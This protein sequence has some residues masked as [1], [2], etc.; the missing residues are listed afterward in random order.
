M[1][2]HESFESH[3]ARRPYAVA[4]SFGARHWTYG[5]LNVLANRFAHTL[6]TAGVAAEVRVGLHL[7]P[8]VELIAAMLGSMKAGG[9]YVPLDPGLPAGRLAQIIERAEP[10][11]L[12]TRF[13]TAADLPGHSAQLIF[14]DNASTLATRS[15]DP[16]LP[17]AAGDLCYVMFTSGS[18]GAP[19][20]VMVTHGNLA[21]LFD[22]IGACLDIDADDV[23]T[24]FHPFSFGFSVW[25]IWCALRHGGRLVI[26][27]PEL[28]TDP[29]RLFNLMRSENVT[30][31]SQTP[32]AF[33][34]NFLS[35]T[36][37]ADEGDGVGATAIRCVVLSGEAVDTGA[38][39]RWFA[40]HGDDG[41]RIVNTYAITEAAGQLTVAEYKSAD[42]DKRATTIVGRPLAHAELAIVDEDWL[43]VAA[44][45]AGELFVGGP[46]VAGTSRRAGIE[47]VTGRA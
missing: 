41:P 12:V 23:W 37:I 15:E 36:F 3:A 26:V 43:P 10:A 38:L 13:V 27:P 32:S 33:R 24:T 28:R 46:S 42:C 39:Q 16:R 5:E 2:L 45:Q 20:G 47:P 8:G 6:I 19:K 14:A 4:L 30:V 40:R 25:E 21:P 29:V 44:G 22:D 35:D 9:A 17:V 7:P 18:T 34:Q 11:V 31:V 1:L